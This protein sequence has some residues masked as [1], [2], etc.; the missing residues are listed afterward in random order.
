M[1]VEQGFQPIPFVEGHPYFTDPALP[2]LLKR[3]LPPDVAP[4]IIADLDR[5]GGLVSTS[6]HLNWHMDFLVQYDQWGR[7]VDDL[8][9]S[10]GWR[11]LKA[12]FQQEGI[13]GIFYERTFKEHSRAYGFAKI[14]LANGDS[15]VID[16]PLSMTDGCARV[17]ELLGTPKAKED[18]LPRLIS[19]DPLI[20]FTAGQWMTERPGGSDI[21]QTETRATQINH[22]LGDAASAYGPKYTLDGFKW[23]SS[24]TDS[25]VALA[26][27]RTG[28]QTDGSRGLSLFLVPLR[29]PLLSEPHAPQPSTISNHIFV[30]RLKNKVGTKILPTA[31]LSLE[32]SEA[33]LLGEPGQ[34]VKL[35]TPVLNITRL[36]S[37]T[38]SVGSLR[39]C[40]AIAT[41][42]ASVRT[43]RGG[44]Q[45]LRD[46]PL[47]VAELTKVSIT[48]RALLHMLFGTIALLGKSECNLA[49]E[50][51]ALR[52]P[53]KACA[54]MGECMTALGG[55]GYMTENDIGRMIQ[56]TMVERIWEGTI[57][58]LSLD[59]VRV[60]SKSAAMDAFVAWAKRTLSSCPAALHD[61]L[62]ETLAALHKA[63]DEVAVAYAT[64]LAPLVARPALFLFS[65]TAASLYL[66]EHAVWALN[67]TETTRGTDV[68]VLKR[69]V[70]EFG[71]AQAVEEVQKARSA[72]SDRL[73]ADQ[74]IAFGAPSTRSH[75]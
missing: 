57:T 35:I 72:D 61:I 74:A 41:A 64:P 38:M 54:A 63:L 28:S 14:L 59:I 24:A 40:L 70:T 19:R 34:G 9:T 8:Q 2:T 73:R 23:F 21:S 51:E 48:Y 52:L 4:A 67:A 31:E 55:A 68:E 29:L 45:L 37:A 6:M 56:D 62:A 65:H 18:I 15:Q 33:Y 12:L 50:E 1:K 42:Y 60:V 7:R 43:I 27:A 22:P 5:F 25:N 20:A 32:G 58:V 16:C 44:T 30:H 53:E 36:H 26:L 71:L 69:W 46:T 47:H 75:L 66:L 13:I 49:S 39:R 3:L 17:I 11:G 10:E